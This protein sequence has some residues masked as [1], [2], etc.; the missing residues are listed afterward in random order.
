MKLN[1]IVHLCH[2]GKVILNRPMILVFTFF[3]FI[4]FMLMTLS[5]ICVYLY[6]LH[7]YY[8]RLKSVLGR[9]DL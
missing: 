9:L 7:V 2:R 1:V 3:R 8:R 6:H 5:P 4:D